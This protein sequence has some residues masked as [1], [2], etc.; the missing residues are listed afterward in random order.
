MKIWRWVAAGGLACVSAAFAGEQMSGVAA[1]IV[2]RDEALVIRSVLP[3]GP[4]EEAG[5]LAEDV[6]LEIDGEPVDGASL[7]QSAERLRGQPFSTVELRVRRD[8]GTVPVVYRVMRK[9]FEV[10]D[11]IPPN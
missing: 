8:G 9:S 2:M 11:S 5:L 10:P 3:D 7:E 1:V 4:A 6:I